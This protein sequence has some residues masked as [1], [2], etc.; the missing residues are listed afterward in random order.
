M[1]KVGSKGN[2]SS[3]QIMSFWFFCG[4]FFFPGVFVGVV[5]FFFCFEAVVAE[6]LE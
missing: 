5:F 1:K 3:G 6:R 4:W 2:L